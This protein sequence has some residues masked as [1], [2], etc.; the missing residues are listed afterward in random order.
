MQ[1]ELFKGFTGRVA[2]RYMTFRP[3]FPFEYKTDPESAN[4]AVA[5]NFETSELTL[6]A[7]YARDEVFLQDDNDRVSMGTSLHFNF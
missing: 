3:T 5:S 7:R 1:R 6:E 2:A 4:T